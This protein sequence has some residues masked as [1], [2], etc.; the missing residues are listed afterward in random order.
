MS[1]G[2]V[3]PEFLKHYLST[4]AYMPMTNKEAL[5]KARIAHNSNSVFKSRKFERMG[6]VAETK[7][8]LIYF[9]INGNSLIIAL[10]EIEVGALRNFLSEW[11]NDK[12]T[13]EQRKSNKAIASNNTT[14]EK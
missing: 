9:S 4:K 14:N 10:D 1:L 3:N 11:K 8:N 2:T 13:R 5:E 6:L 7:E 12:R